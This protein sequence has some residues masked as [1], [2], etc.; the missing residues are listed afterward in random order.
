MAA[1][2]S[3]TSATEAVLP[4]DF[5]ALADALPDA[6]VMLAP[7]GTVGAA[8]RAFVRF[9][10][11]RDP[12]G[13][14]LGALARP[15]SGTLE[16]FLRRGLASSQSVPG[17]LE[18]LVD[19]HE[20]STRVELRALADAPTRR[21]IL[22]VL[23][24]T[25]S[26]RQF[27]ALNAELARRN[28]V[29]AE[30]H[31]SR[32][33]LHRALEKAEITL[34]SIGDAVIATDAAGCIEAMNP[35]AETLTG[36]A[37]SAAQGQPLTNVF[38][39]INEVSREPASNPVA[40]C[41]AEGRIVG[42][43]NHTALIARDGREYVIEDSAAP[44]RS[45][46]GEI[47][48]A[49]LVFRDVTEDRLLQRQLGFM[50]THDALTQLY[51]RRHFERELDRAV[52]VGRR[53]ATPQAMLYIDLDHFKLVNDTAGH[54]VG[55]ELLLAVS[56]ALARRVRSSD[57]LARLG[58]DEFGVLLCSV[59]TDEARH[60]AEAML[61][62]LN[63]IDFRHN[64]TPYDAAASIGIAMIG[65]DATHAADVLRRADIAC[66]VAKRAGRNRLHIHQAS[67]TLE[68][69]SVGEIRQLAWMR[70]QLASDGFRLVFQPI[71][72]ASDRSVVRY[73]VLL[74]MDDEAGR[75][76]SPVS[77][78]PFAERNGLMP[79]IDLWVVAQSFA[80]AERRYREGRPL[81]L[82]VNLSGQTLGD[83]DAV[84]RLR[85]LCDGFFAPQ[86][87]EF[88]I[89][90]TAALALAQLDQTRDFMRELRSRGFRFALDDFGTGFS[91]LAY[92]KYLPVDVVKIDGAFVRD[93]VG[94]AVDQAM[95][96]SICQIARS[97]G[98]QTVAEYVEN[99]AILDRLLD[100]GVDYVQGYHLGRP[101]E[102]PIP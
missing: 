4:A 102:L 93:I 87:I 73:E 9:L 45:R 41:L 35:V 16:V 38:H 30:L 98:K 44:I 21:L 67:D 17:R 96:R 101:G 76:L 22:R 84:T 2:V 43:A 1:R 6:L 18:W 72:R 74:R 14:P 29:L 3:N 19:A 90:E 88:E 66:Y 26:A 75:V 11:G 39:I 8:N 42:L 70:H 62:A 12:A 85:K 55:D 56:S 27:V 33:A 64:G 82:S 69:G 5:L 24:R 25:A 92:L 54:A 47:L 49:I 80:L 48:G 68:S 52:Q 13:Q 97:L 28:A 94:D 60:I 78:I 79:Q 50:A 86:L 65:R 32:D 100:I 36:W 15:A 58:G 40:R 10:G 46:N 89:T 7:D 91:S 20:S 51:N 37:V 57:I 53:S 77:F 34:M 83:A 63:A 59:E 23:A 61:D 71:V 81:A 99:Q 95:V 31:A